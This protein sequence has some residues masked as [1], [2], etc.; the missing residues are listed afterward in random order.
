MRGRCR[1]CGTP[2]PIH[3]GVCLSCIRR[4][5]EET[6]PYLREA[7]RA[8]REEFRLPPAPP[9]SPDGASCGLCARECRIGEGEMGYCGLRTVREGKLVH[10]AGTPERGFLHWYRDPLPT[11]C[12]ADWV[13]AGHTKRG[14]HNLA[15]F[16]AS[17]SLD[18]LFCQNWHFRTMS[19]EEGILSAQD[20]ADKAT[21]RTFCVCF[22]GGDPSSQMPHALASGK[23]LAERGVAVCWE[24]SGQASPELMD[25]AVELS[26]GSGGTVKFDLKAY[27]EVLHLALTGSSNR[28]S[29]ENFRRAGARF[30]ERSAP[31]LVV[32]S[33]LL[34]PGYV[35]A[36]EVG[37]IARFIAEVDPRIPYSLLAFHPDFFLYDLPTTS[38][39]HALE[40]VGVAHSAGLEEVRV[41]NIHLLS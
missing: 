37:R 5:P 40:A 14:Y 30:R 28:A 25:R 20:L 15:V 2:A 23:L 3:L 31:P 12:V 6:L 19:P 1:I 4:R 26:L 29:L 41:G 39:G 11:N 36:E 17:C 16:Y 13:C 21:G 24:T 7:H 10:V 32:A 38:R 9:N 8:A 34:V 33:T 22:F 18:C 27:D 35:D